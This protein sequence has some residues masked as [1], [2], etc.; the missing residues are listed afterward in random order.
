MLNIN[1]LQ[2]VYDNMMEIVDDNILYCKLQLEQIDIR[3]VPSIRANLNM[4]YGIKDKIEEK[5][6]LIE[7]K[8][9]KGGFN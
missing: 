8:I 4:L 5:F 1:E 7:N 3:L 2:V 9:N 6:T